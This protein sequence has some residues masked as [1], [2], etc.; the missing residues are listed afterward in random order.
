MS[1]F[2]TMGNYTIYYSDTDSIDI[3]QPLDLKIVNKSLYIY[4]YRGLMY[5]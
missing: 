5:Y 1:Q 3:D 2:K 4:M